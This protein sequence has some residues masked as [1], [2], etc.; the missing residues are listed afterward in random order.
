M[1]MLGILVLKEFYKKSH[2]TCFTNVR[3]RAR[4]IKNIKR[5]I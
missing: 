5:E 4:F 1:S 2:F 3:K